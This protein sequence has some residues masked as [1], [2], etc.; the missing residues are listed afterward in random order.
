MNRWV[1]IIICSVL[2]LILFACG[3][4]VPVHLRA[5]DESV[6][7]RAGRNTPSF[8]D[9]GLAL[10]AEKKTG[11]ARMLLQAA[12]LANL[13]GHGTLNQAISILEEQKPEL[14]P[15]GAEVPPGW[16]PAAGQS[17]SEPFTEVAIR[18]ANRE[19]FLE[20]LQASNHPAVQE[21]LRFRAATNTTIF[22]PSASSSGQALDAALVIGGLLFESG[23]Y[24]P[25]L[26]NTLF[27]LAA[28]ANRGG[29]S[30]AFELVLA[31]LM[32][33]GQRFNWGQ[34]GAFVR[35]IESAELL[36]LMAALVRQSGGR[37]PLIFAAVELT[38]KPAAVTG[39]LMNFSQTGLSDLGASLR[40]GAGGV[41]ELL[42]RDQ[43]LNVSGLRP[44]LALNYCLRSPTFALILKWILYLSAGFLFA[45][46]LHFARPAVSDLERPL[47][48]RGF[49]V[50][51][52]VLF[53]L[54]FLLV[55]LF[56]SE[57]FLAHESQRTEFRFQLRLPTA[58]GA[59]PAEKPAD[60][61]S[62]MN[63]T[64]LLTM[65][66][67]FV[68]QALLY[69]ASLVK[70]AEVRRQRVPA[71]VKLKLLENEDHLFDSGLY[72]GFLGTII[73]LILVS[74]GVVKQPS[75]MAAYSSTSFGILFVVLFKVANLR[76]YRR[77][78]LL[79]AESTPVE[80]PPVPQNAP[81]TYAAPL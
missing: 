25:A 8:I 17:N 47:Q 43:R 44:Q 35:Q 70:L 50:A 40:F 49:H 57:P 79:E 30:Q 33:L 76:P 12:Q 13:P 58:G 18:L 71:R 42:E 37:A 20:R 54:G 41:N 4:L 10:V 56:V 31:D 78:L 61:T 59:V 45:M 36:R 7:E 67:F 9:R 55:V 63:Q 75:L 69:V 53:G 14:K 27:G 5:V 22:P 2:G 29:S 80:P 64:V 74:A 1:R 72:L 48:V 11:A 19:K 73:S 68:L 34:L 81:H 51:R 3:L 60:H 23:D 26:S 6:I 24:S 46:A 21:L 28:S 15:W 16:P 65:L 52:E 77:K 38:G 66:L 32:S 39:Y 62:F